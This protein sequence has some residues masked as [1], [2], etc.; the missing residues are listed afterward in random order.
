MMPNLCSFV[1][2]DAK[3]NLLKL[4]T[5]SHACPLRIEWGVL[6]SPARAGRQNRYPSYDFVKNF[7]LKDDTLMKSV[8]LCGEAIDLY[9]K[10]DPEL[11][12][13]IQE[14]NARVQL[15]FSMAKYDKK[16]LIENILALCKTH[17]LIVQHNKSKAK[18]V[19]ELI[20]TIEKEY[21]VTGMVDILYDGS[22]GFGRE[23]EKVDAPFQNYWTGYAGGL[24]PE[25][26]KRIVSMIDKVSNEPYSSYYVDMESGVRTDDLFDL[27]KCQAVLDSLVEMKNAEVFS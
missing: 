15:N 22:G 13:I 3:T 5:I 20:E 16:F 1:G 17:S 18:F 9:F 2:V 7:L 6:Y 23:I 19:D 8:H 27:S 4:Q 10:R 21:N 12:D 26:I 11:F 24:K 25:N 14:S